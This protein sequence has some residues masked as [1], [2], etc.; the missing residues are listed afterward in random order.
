MTRRR[1]VEMFGERRGSALPLAMMVLVLVTS[2]TTA[3]LGL[4][5]TEPMIAANLKG[6]DQALALAEAAV[7]R[8]RWALANPAAPA[9][10]LSSPLPNPVPAPYGSQLVPFGPGVYQVAVTG[11]A[12]ANERNI[13]A[14]GSILRDGAALP[15]APPIPQADLFAQRVVQVVVSG[16]GT[17]LFGTMNPPGALTVGGSVQMSGNTAINGNSSTCG[18][19]T[20]VTITTGQTISTSGN[21]SILGTPATST[22]SPSQFQG[23]I[24]SMNDLASL[25][26]LAQSHGT[27]INPTGSSMSLS[28]SNGL[29]FIDTIN[30]QALSNPFNPSIDASKLV[31]VSVSG[32]NSGSGWLVVMGSLQMS[33]TSSYTGLIFA[34]NDFQA[35]GNTHITGAL[36]SQNAVDAIATVIDTQTSGNSS[37]SYDC[38]AIANG[39]GALSSLVSEVPP[40]YGVKA[41]TW[42]S[43][44]VGAC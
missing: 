37:V 23:V 43:C 22:I 14:V 28:L 20:G 42:K 25:K 8:A 24:P 3:F 35:S 9:S 5:A 1:L 16:S 40:S 11:G 34:L 10:G 44:P 32:N 21:A 19:K 4:S 38:A 12:T 31:S 36:I 27:Y 41:G 13:V 30:G 39:G 26:A 33:G 17:A 6:G 18:S 7:E 2:L 29:T 15:G